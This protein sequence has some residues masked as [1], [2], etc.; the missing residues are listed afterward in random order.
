[1]NDSELQSIRLRMKSLML[2]LKGLTVKLSS[3]LQISLSGQLHS[4]S[5]PTTVPIPLKSQVQSNDQ[6]VTVVHFHSMFPQPL[7]SPYG[8]HSRPWS[9]KMSQ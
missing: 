4:H 6:M 1:M 9:V 2:D 5:F 3:Y 8:T 7:K